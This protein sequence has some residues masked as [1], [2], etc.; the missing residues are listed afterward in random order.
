MTQ[1]ARTSPRPKSAAKPV[2]ATLVPG[3]VAQGGTPPHD[4]GAS[5]RGDPSRFYNRE[6]SW[7]QFNR[8]VLEESTNPNHPLLERL[9][10]LSISASNLDEF[11]MVRA[12]GLY[13]QVAAGVT[14]PSQ[15]GLSPAQQLEKINLFVAGLVQ[16]KQASWTTLKRELDE[17]QITILDGSTVR[18]DERIWLEQ[19]FLTHVFPILTPIA[20]EPRPPLSVHLEQGSDACRQ[21]ENASATA[22]R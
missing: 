7:L 21:H 5:P 9:R 1:P 8:R 17:A 11:Y 10:F 3:A 20:V 19:Y 13:G 4:T 22:R 6:L 12:A 18:P 15:D 2:A 14:T 16:E